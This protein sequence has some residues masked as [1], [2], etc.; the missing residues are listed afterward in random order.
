MQ[1]YC[2][3]DIYDGQISDMHVFK[4]HEEAEEYFNEFLVDN[5]IKKEDVEIDHEDYF[6]ATNDWENE[7]VQI[8]LVIWPVEMEE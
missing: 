4:T 7:R 8:E 1:V 3:V 6:Y 5:G 2:A